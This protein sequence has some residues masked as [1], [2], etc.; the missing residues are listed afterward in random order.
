M[1]EPVCCFYERC[2]LTYRSISDAD[3]IFRLAEVDMLFRDV[4]QGL[5]S[6]LRELSKTF[7]ENRITL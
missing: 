4:V 2:S 5:C 1:A 7:V 3:S 6:I